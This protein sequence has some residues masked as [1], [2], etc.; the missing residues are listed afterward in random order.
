MIDATQ[1]SRTIRGYVAEQ[2]MRKKASESGATI[3]C[4]DS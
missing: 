3:S 2:V 4:S 1:W